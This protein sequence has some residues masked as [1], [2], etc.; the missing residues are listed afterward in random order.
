MPFTAGFEPAD[1][2]GPIALDTET[3]GLAIYSPGY[4]LRTVQF[5]DRN[6][7]WVR[8]YERGGVWA[9]NARWALRTGRRFQ[10]HNASF[11]WAVLDRHADMPL[12]SLAPRTK[13]GRASCRERG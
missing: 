5:G 8:P 3:T 6:T 12:E 1:R 2:R 7:A 11:D 9:D 13:I 10:I 4:R